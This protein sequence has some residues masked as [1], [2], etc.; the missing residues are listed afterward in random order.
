MPRS[1]ATESFGGK[2]RAL[3]HTTLDVFHRGTV[4]TSIRARMQCPGHVNQASRS[5]IE[6]RVATRVAADSRMLTALCGRSRASSEAVLEPRIVP[7]PRR[8]ESHD[9]RGFVQRFELEW[10]LNHSVP[11]LRRR[12]IEEIVEHMILHL[13]DRVN[14]AKL[15]AM[16]RLSPSTFFVEF[17]RV[18][19]FTPIAF[20][21]RARVQIA[22]K[23][24]ERTGLQVKQIAALVG[25]DDEFHF[26]RR[27]KAVLGQAP[28][29]YRR[30]RPI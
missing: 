1:I 2:I 17:K 23:L 26:S 21:I 4:E 11:E 22:A 10:T 12:K 7:T 8:R 6:I 25:Y 5:S 15:S 16:A 29:D 18:T 19:G 30:L 24:L 13:D 27:F 14:I 3:R 9:R 28:S 20:L